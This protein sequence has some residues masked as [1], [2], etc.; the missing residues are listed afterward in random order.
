LLDE[1]SAEDTAEG[2]IVIDE[3]DGG[4]THRLTPGVVARPA[5]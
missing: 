5:A 3:Q 1:D 2:F 4:C